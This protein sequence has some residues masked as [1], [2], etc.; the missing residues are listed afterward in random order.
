[1]AIRLIYKN[2]FRA[3][4]NAYFIT[5]SML[6]LIGIGLYGFWDARVWI[7][8][9]SFPL[10]VDILIFSAFFLFLDY[11]YAWLAVIPFLFSES[12]TEI[13]YYIS[14]T[15]TGYVQSH[16]YSLEVIQLSAIIIS[17]I[18]SSY[19]FYRFNF[20]LKYFVFLTF[21]EIAFFNIVPDPFFHRF[22]IEFITLWSYFLYH[23]IFCLTM[24]ISIRRK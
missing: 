15:I 24:A 3:F 18:L 11:R 6:A 17:F 13:L 10:A 7:T 20:R 14:N 23:G 19:F 4:L 22:G 5:I 2:I 1:M 21:I 12:L 16:W 8:P 9:I